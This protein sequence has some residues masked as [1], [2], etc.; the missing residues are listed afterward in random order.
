MQKGER[1]DKKTEDGS[2]L[3]HLPAFFAF[4]RRESVEWRGHARSPRAMRTLPRPPVLIVDDASSSSTASSPRSPSQTAPAAPHPSSARP[5]SAA[6]RSAPA[7]LTAWGALCNAASQWRIS[8]AAAA[9]LLPSRHR[10]AHSHDGVRR[11]YRSDDVQRAHP[12]LPLHTGSDGARRRLRH[13][14]AHDELAHR[15]IRRR[16]PGLR[17]P[18]GG[19]P[20]CTARE[21]ALASA[22]RWWAS[23]R[24]RFTRPTRPPRA[25]PPPAPAR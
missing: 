2:A 14:L 17:P 21:L 10:R 25:S 23:A 5:R 1:C 19:D 13:C 15:A 20:A 22:E 6:A 3:G 18:H 9:S 24:A 4:P 12:W 8:P 16:Y 7:R 11:D